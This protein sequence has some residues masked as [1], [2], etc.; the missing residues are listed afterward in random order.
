M[1]KIT[2]DDNKDGSKIKVILISRAGSEGLDFEN[3]NKFI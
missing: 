1:K 3:I 2:D